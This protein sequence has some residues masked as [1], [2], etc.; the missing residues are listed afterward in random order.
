MHQRSQIQASTGAWLRFSRDSI[1]RG[2]GGLRDH[3]GSDCHVRLLEIPV[4]IHRGLVRAGVGLWPPLL[5][6]DRP[7]ADQRVTHLDVV[8]RRVVQRRVVS[9]LAVE[10]RLAVDRRVVHQDVAIRRGLDCLHVIAA[11]S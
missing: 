9:P 5:V 3:E 6:H 4:A 8:C 7:S 2:R 1:F 10:P 11:S